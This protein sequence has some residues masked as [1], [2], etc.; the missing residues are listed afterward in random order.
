MAHPDPA[1]A[2]E[3]QLIVRYP[4]ETT[5]TLV[6]AE[7]GR[8]LRRGVET[9]DRPDPDRT[10]VLSLSRHDG[11]GRAS[12]AQRRIGARIVGKRLDESVAD[13]HTPDL[14]PC[15]GE[16]RAAQHDEVA[17]GRTP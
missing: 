17:V 14:V 15:L 4:C 2:R 10:E 1:A 12:D 8:H 5:P 13:A 3:C 16:R 9:I 11:T 6:I 7:F